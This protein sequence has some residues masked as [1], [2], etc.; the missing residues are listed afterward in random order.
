M[1]AKEL[2]MLLLLTYGKIR[3]HDTFSIMLP[4]LVD[5]TVIH[6]AACTCKNKDH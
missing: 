3:P 5:L 4:T 1:S 2:G 6:M